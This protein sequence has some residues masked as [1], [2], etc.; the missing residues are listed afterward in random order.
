[1]GNK[2]GMWDQTASLCLD[3]NLKHK[4][5]QLITFVPIAAAQ[6]RKVPPRNKVEKRFSQWS[7]PAVEN[8][9]ER[10]SS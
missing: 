5:L 4:K 10:S 9:F 8:D 7:Q 2:A 1:M 3:S 6:Q